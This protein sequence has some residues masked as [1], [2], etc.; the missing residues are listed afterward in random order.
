M[1]QLFVLNGSRPPTWM[2]PHMPLS[3]AGS[4][5]GLSSPN[6]MKCARACVCVGLW[7]FDIVRNT[8]CLPGAL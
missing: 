6:C 2:A 1:M 7:G 8:H 5:S 4:T 3:W